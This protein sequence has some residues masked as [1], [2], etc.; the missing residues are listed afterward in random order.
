MQKADPRSPAAGRL[1]AF[2]SELSRMN[3]Q[4]RW[5]AG[6]EGPRILFGQCPYAAILAGHPELC[7]MDRELIAAGTDQ[8]VR[9]DSQIGV[10]SSTAC[11]FQLR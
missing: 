3:Y 11:A 6:A 2:V 9:Q 7:Q 4:A 10:G 8:P 5:E 1:A